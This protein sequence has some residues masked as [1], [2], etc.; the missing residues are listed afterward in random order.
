MRGWHGSK[1]KPSSFKREFSEIYHFCV[2]V[3]KSSIYG[4][5]SKVKWHIFTSTLSYDRFLFLQTSRTSRDK[6]C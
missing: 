5:Y 3:K 4:K 1:K 2:W 6:V